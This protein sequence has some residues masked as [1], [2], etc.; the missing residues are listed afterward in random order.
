MGISARPG[1]GS[2]PFEGGVSFRV[3]APNASAVAV[4]GGF[5]GWDEGRD[6]LSPEGNGFWSGD[7]AGASVGD[8]YKY[9]VRGAWIDGTAWRND[10]WAVLLTNSSGDT[11][12][13]E[14]DVAGHVEGY[15]TPARE[16]LVLYELHVGTFS[17]DPGHRGGRGHFGTVIDRLDHLHAL[18]ITA[19]ELMP[20]D[21]FP[22][23]VS[24]GYNPST[25]F[26]IEESYGGPGGLAAL[27]RAAHARGIAVLIDV[28]YNHLGPADLDLWRFDGWHE[29]G[30]GIYFYNDW[31]ARTPWG[32]TR[33]DYGR[34]EVRAYLHDAA[35]RWLEERGCDGLRWDSTGSIRNAFGNVGA[36]ETALPDGWSLM[37]WINRDL[38]ARQGWKFSIAE[39]MS[40]DP[41]L[42]R[43][44]SEGGAGFDAQWS[45]RFLHA[46]RRA[47]VAGDDSARDMG[48][49]ASVLGLEGVHGA[50]SRVLYTESHDEVAS[51]AGEA[52]LPEKVSPGQG[53]DSW[54]RKRSTLAAGAM[55]TAPGI[56]MLFMGQE[57][58]ETGGW[59]DSRG[60]D[61]SRC[62]RLSGIVDLYRD[63][64]RLRRDWHG[65]TAGL[66]GHGARVSHV[67]HADKLVALHRWAQG[68]PGDDVVALL[69]F[70]SRAYADYRIGLP[71]AGRWRVRFN[72]DWG[73]YGEGFSDH[74]SFD[75]WAEAGAAQDG[76]EASGPVGIG[77]Y[78]L[79]ILSQDRG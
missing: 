9:A 24:W 50:F 77:A 1:M 5:N 57:F 4:V 67:N 46:I 49:V 23:D 54:A 31:R 17:I 37:Q 64:I 79:V 74:P 34:G 59:S 33:P 35:M 69:N 42:V 32:D 28:V 48:E 76:M 43:P 60:L 13:T 47:V 41:A 14:A 61:W 56:P 27:V 22:G 38:H 66:K 26:A 71:R 70:S 62:D 2:T 75:T 63:L 52:R 25:A 6:P 7:V 29:G 11:V 12:V 30:G 20:T 10:P 55:M 39:D 21:E 72:G 8:R 53:E 3:W 15:A 19:I 16:E 36:P 65:N 18:G 73:G 78:T 68:G 45:A 40:D 58:L 51:S 44:V